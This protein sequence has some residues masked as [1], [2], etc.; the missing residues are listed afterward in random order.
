MSEYT[1]KVKT[2]IIETT[3]TRFFE[4]QLPSV[5]G[6]GDEHSVEVVNCEIDHGFDQATSSC[7]LVIKNTYDSEG[8]IFR[9]KPMDRVK[10]RQGWNVSST[11]KI[12][13]LGF[14]D[15][16][17]LDNPNNEQRL[18]CRD[19]LKVAQDNYLIQSNRRVYFIDPVA[20]ELDDEGN[21]MGGQP[22][23]E[24]TAKAIISEFLINSGIG[25]HR[26]VLDDEL[27][28]IIIGNNAVAVFVY[29][30]ALDAI[31]RIC[32]LIGYRLW[33]D[34]VGCVRCREVVNIASSNPA[35]T[36]QS[37]AE[38]YD[39]DGT[40]TVTTSGNLLSI[41]TTRADDVRNWITIIGWGDL[42]TTVIG[43]SPYVPDPPKYK[44]VEIRSYLLDT[45]ELLIAVA[46]RIYNDLNRLRYTASASIEGDPRLSLGMIVRIYDPFST[47][48]EVD[49]ILH[50]YSSSFTAGSWIMDLTL[51]GG[52]GEGSPP[53]G[54]ISPIALFDYSVEREGLEFDNIITVTVD[55]SESYSP[56]GHDLSYIWTCSGY[57]NGTGVT[58]VYGTDTLDPLIVTLT[59]T[60]DGVPPLTDSLTRIISLLPEEG[61]T[62]KEKRVFVASGSKV[63]S[64]IDSGQTWFS[65]DIG[66][67]TSCVAADYEASAAIVGTTNGGIWKTINGGETWSK[68]YT[69][70]GEVVSDIYIDCTRNLVDYPSAAIAYFGTESGKL[71]KTVD[72]MGSWTLIHT[73]ATDIVQ[74]MS[75]HANSNKVVVGC[76]D[77]VWV[78]T[79][80]GSSWTL[81]L[82]VD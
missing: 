65:P 35:V 40:W 43:E 7:T 10:I 69:V 23:E 38:T 12:A 33:V 41:K 18:E 1:K 61:T 29:E 74:I 6:I 2:P 22:P 24:R 48:V 20:D 28:N 26:Q 67:T 82:S 8:N 56:E 30:S 49:Y 21:P 25:T 59:V 63:F 14:V 5:D 9:F 55:A 45:S 72:S 66:E 70:S 71:Y 34:Q 39:E 80:G 60:D 78:S 46:E 75:S 13:F 19:I 52:V 31:N 73:F 15:R 44:R 81:S 79:N 4:D 32:E 77:S 50:A 53:A 27:D 42:S 58:Y 57:I 11:L 16:A 3:I 37:Q 36:Y 76:E 68:I 54:R 47:Y 51:T 17:E 64:T 62:V